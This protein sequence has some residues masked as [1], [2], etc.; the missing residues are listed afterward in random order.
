MGSQE[1]RLCEACLMDDVS[2]VRE[3]GPVEYVV[4]VPETVHANGKLHVCAD[5]AF[6]LDDFNVC[7]RFMYA[8]LR[9]S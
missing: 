5:H 1:P 6:M 4:T 3:V 9:F 2:E 7:V 8:G